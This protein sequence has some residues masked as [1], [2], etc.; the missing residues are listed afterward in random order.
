VL[1]PGRNW[2]SATGR[3][4]WGA[5]ERAFTLVVDGADPLAVGTPPTLVLQIEGMLPVAGT[6]T[7]LMEIREK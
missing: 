2:A 6:V 1:Q 7:G 4:R 5:E 3:L